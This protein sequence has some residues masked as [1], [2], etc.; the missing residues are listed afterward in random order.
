VFE[1]VRVLEVGTWIMVPANLRP[2]PEFGQQTEEVLLEL[3]HSWDDIARL[4]ES[5]AVP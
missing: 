1:G 2:A 4:K 5:G 3:G